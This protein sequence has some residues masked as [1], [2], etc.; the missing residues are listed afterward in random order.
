MATAHARLEAAVKAGDVAGIRAAVGAGA[1]VNT[2][3]EVPALGP[4]RPLSAAA[5]YGHAAA[6]RVLLE[7][8][9]DIHGKDTGDRTA[10]QLAAAAGREEVVGILIAAGATVDEVGPEGATALW[11]ACGGMDCD[12]GLASGVPPQPCSKASG[13]P[14]TVRV[15]LAAGADPNAVGPGGVTALMMAAMAGHDEIV[16]M[17]LAAG[18]GATVDVVGSTGLTALLAACSA[19]DMRAAAASGVPPQPGSKAGGHPGTVRALLA[20]GADPNAVGPDGVTALMAAAAAGYIPVIDLL[21]AAGADPLHSIE[22]NTALHGASM[23]G[24]TAAV[25]RLLEAGARPDAKTADGQTPLDV[26]CTHSI[27]DKAHEAAIRELLLHPP[28]L[29]PLVPP[30]PAAPPAAAGGAGGA[31][32][33]VVGPTA[34]YEVGAKLGEGEFGV[35]HAATATA[36]AAAAGVPAGTRVVIKRTK[37]PAD[38]R[39]LKEAT[40]LAKVSAG[41]RSMTVHA[42]HLTRHRPPAAEAA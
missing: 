25:R 38:E 1:D 40:T 18:A 3:M 2:M 7:L 8:G 23:F 37:L 12:A 13:H 32:I 31:A 36:A 28:P 17:L 4:V 33:A 41:L 34:R 42:R 16:G 24:R 10:L 27:A 30:T 39:A 9:A 14:G 15:L 5:L 6:V 11:A 20:G 35:V 21:L 26:V 19:F 22:G 29:R